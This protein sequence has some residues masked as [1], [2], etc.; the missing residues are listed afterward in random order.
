VHLSLANFAVDFVLHDPTSW[1]TGVGWG[2]SYVLLQGL[3]PGNV[4]A[5]FH[6]AYLTAL[7]ELGVVGFVVLCALLLAPVFSPRRWLALGVAVF[8]VVY[9]A[10]LDPIFWIQ[11]AMVWT[12]V[13]DVETDEQAASDDAEALVQ[14]RSNE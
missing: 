8:A 4:H 6:S 11:L 9:Q 2:A 7:V 14:S 5:N 13:D 1:L 10:L 12:L 3:F